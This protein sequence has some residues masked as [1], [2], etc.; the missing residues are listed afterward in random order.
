MSSQYYMLITTT[1]L[2]KFSTASITNSK[3]TITHMA[4][5]DANGATPIPTV[6]RTALI[7]ERTRI[8]VNS[9]NQN[10]TNPNWIE[11]EA[12]IPAATGGFNI[13]EVGLYADGDLVAYGNYPSTF[14][15]LLTDGTSRILSIKTIIQLDNPT[16]VNL[17]IDPNVITATRKYVDD[18]IT[19]NNM[20]GMRPFLTKALLDAYAGSD[21]TTFIG[22]VTNDSDSTV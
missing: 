16:S 10:G 6:G 11:V 4:F 17:V 5:G 3:V 14:K 15:P 2:V 20:A 22:Q 13:R 12:I 19:F 21:K 9:V 7:N 8:A 18:R 1:G